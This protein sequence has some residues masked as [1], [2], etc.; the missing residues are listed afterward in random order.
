MIQEAARDFAQKAKAG[1]IERDTH[2][3][4]PT[5][6]V[7]EMGELGFMG[8]MTSPDFGAVG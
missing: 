1:V 5:E 7:K 2:M 4:Y 6:E 3:T 8:I